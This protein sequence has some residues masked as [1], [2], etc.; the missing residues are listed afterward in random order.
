MEIAKLSRIAPEIP[1]SDLEEAVESYEQRLGFRVAMQMPEP[2]ETRKKPGQ[3][4]S[5]SEINRQSAKTC[6]GAGRKFV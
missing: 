1:V 2:E 4:E 3:T 5:V 6:L